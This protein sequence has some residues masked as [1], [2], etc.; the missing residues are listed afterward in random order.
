MT[1]KRIHV[2]QRIKGPRGLNRFPGICGYAKALGVCRQHLYFVLTGERHSPRI[3]AWLE[4]HTN[5]RREV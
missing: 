1:R 4:Q 3:E 5:L 2:T